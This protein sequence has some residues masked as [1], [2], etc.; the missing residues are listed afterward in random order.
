MVGRSNH[1]RRRKRRGRDQQD[2]S[3]VKQVL[4]YSSILISVGLSLVGGIVIGGWIAF[5]T[6]YWQEFRS[7]VEGVPVGSALS[8]GI[9][10]F[11]AAA[12]IGL[13]TL[14]GNRSA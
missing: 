1:D 10:L 14:L 8:I 6:P 5:E 11:V 3:I 7:L 13:V 12:G 9:V 2:K 4:I